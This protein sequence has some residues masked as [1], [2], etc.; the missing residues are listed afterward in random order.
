MP[1]SI[2]NSRYKVKID[3]E[4]GSVGNQVVRS[5]SGINRSTPLCPTVYPSPTELVDPV[6]KILVTKSKSRG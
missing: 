3:K 6:F 1:T 5:V 4:I 2:D